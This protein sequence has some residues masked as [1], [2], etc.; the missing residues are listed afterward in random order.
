MR[1]G[2][3]GVWARLSYMN[4]ITAGLA[5]TFATLVSPT[6]I[7][8]RGCVLRAEAFDPENFERWWRATEGTRSQIEYGMNHVHLWDALPGTG[9]DEDE[10]HELQALC[11]TMA[12]AW[13]SGLA[14]AFPER[15]F[16]VTIEESYG[17]SLYVITRSAD[18]PELHLRRSTRAGA[19]RIGAAQ[20]VAWKVLLDR[21]RHRRRM[22]VLDDR[23]LTTCAFV[24]GFGIA[25]DD[26]VVPA[27]RDWLVDRQPRYKNYAFE[28]MVLAEVGLRPLGC[29]EPAPLSD[30]EHRQALDA[31][32]DLLSEFL[33]DVSSQ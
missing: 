6:W 18:D 12:R 1:T 31:L 14:E 32:A 16:H 26:G 7:E 3:I 11:A 27:F 4:G 23:F 29:T 17:P 21:I 19:T 15:E 9:E 25:R 30:A 28:P 2:R 24:A 8:Y 5:R 22:H 13:K 10:L 33:D 20:V